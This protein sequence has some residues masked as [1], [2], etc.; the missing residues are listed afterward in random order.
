MPAPASFNKTIRVL[1]SFFIAVTEKA[2][3]AS[4]APIAVF[5]VPQSDKR[6]ELYRYSKPANQLKGPIYI[7]DFFGFYRN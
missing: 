6:K 2:S 3:R 4:A 7:L 5:N 1:V